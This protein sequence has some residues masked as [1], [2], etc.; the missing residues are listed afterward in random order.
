MRPA[1]QSL[2]SLARVEI[3]NAI[4]RCYALVQKVHAVD[5][6]QATSTL[7]TEQSTRASRPAATAFYPLCIDGTAGNGHDTLF[8]TQSVSE[9]SFY[10]EPAT[11]AVIT[12]DVQETALESTKKRLQKAGLEHMVQL[13]HDSHANLSAYL[14]TYANATGAKPEKAE[15]MVVSPTPIKAPQRVVQP[16]VCAAMYNFGYL[17]GSDHSI[18]TSAESSLASINSLLPYMLRG[19]VIALHCY[20]GQPGGSEELQSI[21]TLVNALPWEAWQVSRYEFCNKEWNKEVL[22]C[23]LKK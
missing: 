1:L 23:I 6:E 19:G 15:Q 11:A 21:S 14:S 22:F 9:L 20:T 17:P 4:L 18:N 12:F 8:L 2:T 13:V 7:S 16:V 3:K 5:P 10:I